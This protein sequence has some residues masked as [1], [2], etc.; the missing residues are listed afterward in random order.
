MKFEALNSR[1]ISTYLKAIPEIYAI[2][3]ES[4]EITITEIGD[5]NLNYVYFAYNAVNPE[6]S[7]VVKQAPP[8]M[9]LAGEAWP[10]SRQRIEREA[11]A[12]NRF[13]KLC[14]QHVPKVYHVDRELFLIVMQRLMT[15]DV[16]RQG[17]INGVTYPNLARHLS[18][19]L[20]KTLFFGSDLYLSSD[21]K[22]EAAATSI[23]IELCKITEN[24]IFTYPFEN[25]S[26]NTYNPKLERFVIE[27]INQSIPLRTA[28]A[29]MKWIFMNHSETLLHGDLHT[30]SIMV[31]QNETFVIDPEFAFYGPLGF[32]IG[33][34]LANFILAYFSH[35]WHGRF[36]S[37]ASE[38][39]R[40]WLLEQ[41]REIWLGF[42]NS[43]R[44]LWRN[45]K[46]ID[47]LNRV[48]ESQDDII[49]SEIQDY[50]MN[51]FFCDAMGFVGCEIIRR[52]IGMAKV[53]DIVN[54][55]GSSDRLLVEMR[56]LRFAEILL[57]EYRKL[58]SINQ[59]L[60][61]VTEMQARNEAWPI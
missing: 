25:H 56:A 44:K 43:F 49:F 28:V 59:V 27:K 38:L 58:T 10:L 42:S 34:L 53:A 33:V 52:I 54:I 3:G 8:F 51:R 45:H 40:S 18:D 30:G 13:G 31:N 6:K 35:D 29:D 32:D 36:D 5:G 22:K 57:I 47:K 41:I 12:L 26:S 50:A 19:Y 4:D 17:L 2:L 7:V 46:N 39:Y 37:E 16:L 1:D 20:A 60:T 61:L 15:H 55:S 21:E 14:P 23:N 48:N 11:A 9:R 24:L